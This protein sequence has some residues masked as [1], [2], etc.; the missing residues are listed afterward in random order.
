MLEDE[1]V[2]LVMND[3]FKEICLMFSFIT[4][5][6]SLEAESIIK[7]TSTGQGI[8]SGNMTVMYEQQ[9]ENLFSIAEELAQMEKYK[10]IASVISLDTIIKA[11]NEVIINTGTYSG[12]IKAVKNN[13]QTKILL[14][15]KRRLLAERGVL[16]C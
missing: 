8:L 14:M 16:V 4:G 3:R 2:S 7:K 9:T 15:K 10:K 12:G 1:R 13:M 5:I 11:M 6:S